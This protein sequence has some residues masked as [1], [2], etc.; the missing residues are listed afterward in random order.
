M[1]P[2]NNAFH[3][4][5]LA[6]RVAGHSVL[7]LNIGRPGSL[8]SLLRRHTLIP[9]AAIARRAS[10]IFCPRDAG[11]L[12]L[13]RRV[14]I[15]ARNRWA[16]A[17]PLDTTT[18]SR[19]VRILRWNARYSARYARRVLSVSAD[20]ASVIPDRADVLVIPHG[21]DLPETWSNRESSGENRPLRLLALGSIK[22][23]KRLDVVIKIAAELKS[24]S[25]EV[26]LRIVGDFL[27]LEEAERLRELST[28]LLGYNALIGPT[29]LGERQNQLCWADALLMSSSFESFGMAMVEAMRSGALVIAPK[30]QLAEEICGEAAAYYLEGNAADGAKALLEAIKDAEFRRQ[31]GGER[32]RSFSWESCVQSTVALLMAS[33]A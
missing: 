11:P 22:V 20:L 30:S 7:R 9:V 26:D 14:V 28:A 12:L 23:H 6:L 29:E 2:R 15:L 33:R 32:S 17:E 5:E 16:W 31:L 8:L 4:E 1:L 18:T 25:R 27:D 19:S 24:L 13:R 3:K 10:V 21:C